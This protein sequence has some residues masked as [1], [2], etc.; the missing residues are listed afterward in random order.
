MPL[1]RDPW[2]YYTDDAATQIMPMWYHLGEKVRDGAWPPVLDVQSWMGGNLAVEALFGVWNPVNAVLWVLVSLIPDLAVAAILVRTVAFVLLALG[3]YGLC[4]EYGAAR[5]ASSAVAVTLPFSGSL[6]Y[7]DAAKWP[8][9]LVAFV[10]V[11]YLWWAARRMT[12]GATNALGV[13]ALGALAVT[14][15]NPYSM[16]AVC[17]VLLGLLVE[18]VLLGRWRAARHLMLVSVTIASVVPLVY[19]P[20]LLSSSVTWR[21]PNGIG[22]SGTLTPHL[23]DL[24]NFSV[25]TYVP[26]IPHVFDAAVYFCWFA[27]PLA[28][29]LDWRVLRRRW[30][31][32]AGSLVVGGVFLLLARGPSELWM[33]RWPLRV[34]HYG[35]LA[36][37]VVL[38]VLLSAGLRTDHV[39]R[40]AASMAALVLINGVLVSTAART[41]DALRRD[42]VSL[43][44][45]AALTAL[46]FWV[47]R[48]RGERWLGAVLHLGTVVIFVLQVFWFLGYHGAATYYFPRSPEQ[49]RTDFASHHT[50]R[51]LQI[52]DTRGIGAPDQPRPA[53]RDLLPGNLHLVTEVEAVN[54][55]TGMGFGAFSRDLCMLYAGATC[56]DAYPALWRVSPTVGAPLADLL[57]LDTVVVQNKLIAAPDVPPGWRVT[58]RNTRVTVL[59]RAHSQAVWPAGRLSWASPDVHVNTD[60]SPDDQHE[61]LRVDRRGSSGPARL[62][63]ARLAWPGYT[64]KVGDVEVPTRPGPSGLLEVALPPNVQNGQLDITW[65][66]PGEQVGLAIGSAG[67]L[68][69]AALGG[70]QYRQ[71]RRTRPAP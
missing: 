31:E 51:V 21:R 32:L 24:V 67:L 1:L 17:L 70:F 49:A 63:F 7:F 19:L 68:A 35:Y 8:A 14:A 12:R 48:S 71:K 45:I 53:W 52:A 58:E 69:A 20:L 41:G 37:A 60:D 2:F 64:A 40:R 23:R 38:A 22:Y 47:Y 55:Y 43:A 33:F 16:L 56:P 59:Q 4:R 26:T 42:L 65:H 34:V 18:T 27:L 28:A 50:G 9:A 25:P 30:R 5:W 11:P 6:F 29:W 54:A 36:A 10:W 61:T 3:C 15:G 57:R 62:I 39:R 44:L 13:W 66:P 46:A